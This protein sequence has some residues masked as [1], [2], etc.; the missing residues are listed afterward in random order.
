[1]HRAI[2]MQFAKLRNEMSSIHRIYSSSSSVEEDS[3]FDLEKKKK[4]IEIEIQ[5][6]R[7]EGEYFVPEKVPEKN[8]NDLLNLKQRSQRMKYYTF[9]KKREI[10][11][12]I[13]KKRKEE[14]E[15]KFA[16]RIQLHDENP[17]IAYG[18]N[19]NCMFFRI[20]R[21]A[22]DRFYKTN[23][24]HSVV[25]GEKLVLD[26]GYH[27]NMSE[28]E[29]T[30]CARQVR[31]LYDENKRSRDPFDLYLCNLE[32]KTKFE[33]KIGKAIG[34]LGTNKCLVT[35][36]DKSYLDI[37][38]KSKL[39]YLTPDCRNDLDEFDFDSVYIIGGLVEQGMRVPLAMAKA[40]KEGLRMAR[41]PL[42]KY[43]GRSWATRSLGLDQVVKI[44]L[45][46]KNQRRWDEAFQDVEREEFNI[47]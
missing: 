14:N 24:M 21:Q 22:M 5:M 10:G 36:S 39:V 6:L 13:R 7:E 34:N 17:H 20:R 45:K 8:W 47:Q 40:K 3:R 31:N 32:A 19:R 30:N 12:E 28:N 35:A 33:E 16:Q 42:A 15:T 1:M 29:I 37:F 25:H 9:L 11:F 41:L 26:L 23:S 27:E 2:T 38:P 44:L 46:A 43:V 18:L 4:M